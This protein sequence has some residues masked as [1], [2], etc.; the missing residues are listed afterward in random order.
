MPPEPNVA[1]LEQPTGPHPSRTSHI[2]RWHVDQIATDDPPVAMLHI[3]ITAGGHIAIKGLGLDH[4]HATIVL[5]ELDQVR[6]QIASFV[7]QPPPSN[8]IPLHR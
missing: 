1:K 2:K 5:D 4:L 7:H 6:E 3:A 8:V